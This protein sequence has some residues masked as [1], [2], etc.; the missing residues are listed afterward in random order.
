MAVT[1]FHV[2][3][4]TDLPADAVAVVLA[5]SH[6][7]NADVPAVL[8]E[9]TTRVVAV[10]VGVLCLVT[11]ERQVLDGDPGNLL[12][13]QDRKERGRRGLALLPQVFA[14]GLVKLETVA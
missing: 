6:L 5:S 8:E 14:Q 4:M 12:T 11:V 9:D 2:N 13:A 7:T 3:V 10:Q 1:L